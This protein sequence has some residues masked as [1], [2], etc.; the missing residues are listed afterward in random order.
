M[1]NM[2]KGGTAGAV[3][4]FAAVVAYGLVKTAPQPARVERADVVVAIRVLAVERVDIQLEVSSQGSVAP[5]TKSELIPEVNGRVQWVS[6]NL[7]AGGY[8]ARDEVLLRL[9][10]QDYQAAVARGRASLARAEAEEELA[11]FELARM[12]ELVKKKLIS[13]ANLETVQRNHRITTASLEEARIA[14]AQAQRDLARTEIRAP[15]DGLVSTQKVDLGQYLGRGDSIA[16][17][18]AG[19]S[20]EVRLPVADKQLA[21]LDLP[22]GYRGELSPEQAPAV[23]LSTA[24]GGDQHQ[25]VGSLVR[26]EAEIDARSRMVTAVARVENSGGQA[27]NLPPGL[28]V[29]ATIKGRWAKDVVLLP[30]S[31]L[32]NQTQVLVVDKDNRLHFRE[33]EILRFEQDQV[34][35]QAGLETGERVNI[36][37]IQVV[38][39]GMRVDPTLQASG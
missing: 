16:S 8:F 29:K 39:E 33:V 28:F 13:Q 35:V 12:E 7:V 22:L 34:I 30:R 15:Y 37:P 38:V 23:I 19:E 32:R 18:Y 9:A 5:A 31:A 17:I 24:Y 36:S 20:V 6:P 26:T 14:L 3:L 27:P 1:N 2:V 4:L 21:Y 10:D 25:W 11:R